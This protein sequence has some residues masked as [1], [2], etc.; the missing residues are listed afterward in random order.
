MPRSRWIRALGLTDQLVEYFKP[1]DRP[2]WMS[3]DDYRS[4]AG[5]IEVRELRYRIEVPG[6]GRV[7]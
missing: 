2:A 1:A 3:E 6:S 4:L 5:S 7:R